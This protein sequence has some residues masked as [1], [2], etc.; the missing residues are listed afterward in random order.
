MMAGAMMGDTSERATRT[1]G[2]RELEAHVLVIDEAGSRRVPL[3]A[4]C[5][6]TIGRAEYLRL[7][8]LPT[9]GRFAVI[10]RKM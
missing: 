4:G 5:V 10:T 7:E 9:R 6:L 2:R 1:A 3:P 8:S